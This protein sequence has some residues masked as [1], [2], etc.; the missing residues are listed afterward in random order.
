MNQTATLD[1]RQFID[2]RPLGRFQLLVATMCGAVIFMDGYDAQV[3][4]FVAP[5]LIVQMHITRAAF[6]PEATGK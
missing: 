3:M 2:A 5:A 6:G 1:F 4:G